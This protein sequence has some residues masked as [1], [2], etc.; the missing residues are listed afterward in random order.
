[1]LKLKFAERMNF[2]SGFNT[3]LFF[4]LFLEDKPQM[5]FQNICSS[6]IAFSKR[7]DS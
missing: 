5:A 1:M 2:S 3:S 7:P 6:G 4:P